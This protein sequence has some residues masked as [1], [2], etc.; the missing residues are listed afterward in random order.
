MSVY[1]IVLFVHGTLGAL[2]LGSYWIAAL[3]RKG[4]GPHKLAGKVYVLVMLGVLIPALPL[5]VRVLEKSAVFG[6]FFFYLLLITGT[7]VWQGWFAVRNKRDFARYAG[8]GFRRIAWA[9]IVG[10]V[11]ILALGAAKLQPVL[12]GFSAVGVLGGRGMLKL[13]RTGPVH[14]R[15][16]MGEHLG[17]MLGC[18]VATHIAFLLIGLPR[19]LPGL[20][21]ASLQML[22]WLGPL[23]VAFVARRWLGRKYLPQLA[24]ESPTA[25][26]ALPGDAR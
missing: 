14:P 17:A 25:S 6:A 19:L 23:A 12:L 3:A 9:N 26:M 5:A 16:W 2:A 8:P 11:V 1:Q 7:S 13:A 20:G 18:G 22:G 24:G 21:G 10:G 15:W 4:S